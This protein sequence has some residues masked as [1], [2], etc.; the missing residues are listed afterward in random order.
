MGG[1]LSLLLSSYL[2]GEVIEDD[3]VA[4][5]VGMGPDAVGE[6]FDHVLAGGG[7]GEGGF[8]GRWVGGWLS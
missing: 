2:V 3:E 5:P 4:H 1:W 8:W 6:D 7:Q